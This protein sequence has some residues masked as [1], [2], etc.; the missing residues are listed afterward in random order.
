M[1]QQWA[2]AADNPN[3][4]TICDYDVECYEGHRCAN[5]PYPRTCDLIPT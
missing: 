2:D 3:H 4:F 5:S 1:C